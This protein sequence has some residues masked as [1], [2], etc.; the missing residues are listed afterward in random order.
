MG[1]GSF[2][3]WVDDL[4]VPLRR[5]NS[6]HLRGTAAMIM[7]AAMVAAA[8]SFLSVVIDHYDLRNN[9]LGYRRFAFATQALGW[10]LFVVA[11]VV[12]FFQ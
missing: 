5:G 1:W 12:H 8:L 4:I 6:L 10:L 3:I 11:M 7:F 2:G 9:E